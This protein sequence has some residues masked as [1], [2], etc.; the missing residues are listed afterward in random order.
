M[1]GGVRRPAPYAD[2]PP[3]PLPRLGAAAPA[4]GRAPDG[5]PPDRKVA[6]KQIPLVV[7]GGEPAERIRAR[8]LR[9]ARITA[10]LN[11]VDGVVRIANYFDDEHNVWLELEYLDALNLAELIQATGGLPPAEVASATRFTIDDP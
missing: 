2:P 11:E 10:S 9:E 8:T 7:P 1:S 5:A 6:L 3:D 4:P